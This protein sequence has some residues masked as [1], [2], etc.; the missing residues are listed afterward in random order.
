[1][2]TPIYHFTHAKNLPTILRAGRLYC[3]S[4][5]SDSD[6]VVNVSHQ[7]VQEK[8]R[9]KRVRCH[10]GGILHDYVPF[11]FAPR[12]P[13]MYVI[14]RGGVEGYDTNTIPLIYLV[15]SV[16]RIQEMNLQFA[17][18]DG[19]PV[20]AL[21]RF[22][23]DIEDLNRVDWPVMRAR[24]WKE[25][26]EDPDKSRRRQAEFLIHGTFPWDAIEF[27]AVKNPE[28]KRRLEQYLVEQWPDRVKSVKVE[29]DWYFP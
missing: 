27:L 19:H 16:E 10:P 28:M 8:R 22:Y 18:S 26:E 11:Y 21:S 4:Q 17:F 20:V 3:K 12:S 2:T 6:Q 5:I 15:S 9:N 14:S 29:P 24:L 25:T 7:S 13:M 23:N 1:M